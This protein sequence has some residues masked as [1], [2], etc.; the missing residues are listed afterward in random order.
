MSD[1]TFEEFKNIIDQLTPAARNDVL[2][3]STFLVWK[4]THKPAPWRNVLRG[5]C[6]WV[7]WKIKSFVH[8]CGLCGVFT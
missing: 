2:D 7:G 8:A 3:Y 1:Q 5:G 4:Q 6:L